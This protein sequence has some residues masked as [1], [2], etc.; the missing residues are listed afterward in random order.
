MKFLK[1]PGLS[2]LTV[3]LCFLCCLQPA[4]AENA[5]YAF[6]NKLNMR[7]ISIPP[8]TFIMGSPL[9]EMGRESDETQHSVTISKGFFISETEVTQGQWKKLMG[10]NPSGFNNL[11]P[12]RP[13]EQ[14]SWNDCMVF[15]DKLNSVEGTDTYR[16]PTEA[17]WEYACRAGSTS[18]FAGGDITETSCK[19]IPALADMAWYCANSRSETHP[20]KTKK[21]NAWGLYDMHGN[22]HEWCLDSCTSRNVWTRRTGVITATYIDGVIDPV[23][24]KGEL[25]IFRGGCW[26][27]SSRYARS[28]DRN[29][30]KPIARRTY[31]GFRLVKTR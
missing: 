9:D 30:F 18:A 23:S 28:A 5:T 21:P 14:V 29:Y 13:V 31:I 19:L 3:F 6:T 1:Q 2:L 20:V 8:G 12:D 17:E 26:N 24:T 22:V 15:I 4:E 7:F 27:Q 25:K 16:L 11:G 10:D